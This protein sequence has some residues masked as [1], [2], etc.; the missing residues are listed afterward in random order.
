MGRGVLGKS[1]TRRPSGPR[2]D[3]LSHR[4]GCDLSPGVLV[5][6][7]AFWVQPAGAPYTQSRERHGPRC[8]MLG[9]FVAGSIWLLSQPVTLN[10]SGAVAGHLE[11]CRRSSVN[12]NGRLPFKVCHS[13][14]ELSKPLTIACVVALCAQRPVPSGGYFRSSSNRWHDLL[15]ATR[16]A[17]SGRAFPCCTAGTKVSDFRKRPFHLENAG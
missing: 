8:S 17:C 14:V 15:V 10:L 4:A 1:G 3:A 13:S 2:I 11:G 16:W 7:R 9:D 12:V 6:E 5:A